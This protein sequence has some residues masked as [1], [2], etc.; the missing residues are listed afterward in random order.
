[1]NT[2]AIR[3]LPFSGKEKDWRMWSRKFLAS[4]VAKGYR[5]AV[6]P[7]DP[8]V[9]ADVDENKNA[10]SDLILS[11]QDE[12]TFGIID[13][14]KS[15][16][17]SDGDARMAWNELKKKYEPKTG[18]SEVRTKR[19]FNSSNLD[20]GQDPDEW[21]HNLILLQ[22]RLQTMGTTITERDVMI[23]ILGNLTEDYE[24]VIDYSE[25]ELLNGSLTLDALRETLRTKFEKLNKKNGGDEAALFAKQFKGMCKVCGKIGHKDDDCFN[26][27]KNKNKKAEYFKRF[28]KK[29]KGKDLSKIKCFNCNKMGHYSNK[30]PDKRKPEADD[31]EV[32]LMA[33]ETSSLK[34]A[35]KDLWIADT[36]ASC[37]MCNDLEGLEDVKESKRTIV[38]GNGDEMKSTMIGTW[39]G[40]LK[41]KEG[42]ETMITL[43]EVSYVPTLSANLL[44][45]T[46]VMIGGWELKGTNK[47]L[48]IQKGS[49]KIDFDKELKSGNG[50]LLGFHL[51]RNYQKEKA[52]AAQVKIGLK[53]AH[54]AFGH[55]DVQQVKA[56]L[57]NMGTET[58]ND[59]VQCVPCALAKAQQKAIS[60]VDETKSDKPG[61]RLCVDISS[62]KTKSTIKKRFWVL[63]IDQAT[64]MKWSYFVPKKD[65]QVEHL[66][67]LVKQINNLKDRKVEYVRCDNAGENKAFEKECLKQG[68]NITFEYT[69][70]NTPQQNGQV[71]RAFATLYGKMRAMLKSAEFSETE[72]ERFWHE[73]ASTATKTDNVLIRKGQTGS[74]FK[75]FYGKDPDYL[76][77]LKPFG[78]KGV[79]T[80]KRGG[81]IK[82]KL[83]DRGILCTFMG[84]ALNHTGDTFRMRNNTTGM[85]VI[86]RDVQWIKESE[87]KATEKKEQV[88][89]IPLFGEELGFRRNPEE[90][91]EFQEENVRR[92]LFHNYEEIPRGENTSGSETSGDEGT[93][94][95]DDRPAPP[96]PREVR[97]L[98]TYNNPGRLERGTNEEF[99]FCFLTKGGKIEI[100]E[101][102]TFQEAWN[103]PDEKERELWRASIRL[104]FRQMLR[105][106]VWKRKG[107][108]NN[109]P[110]GRKGLGMKW[111]FKKK[112]NGVYRS[113]L[114]AKGY[115]QLAGIDFQYNFAP[116][117]NDTTVKILL[118]LWLKKGYKTLLVDVKTAFLYG[119]LEEELYAKIPEGYE[120]F[121]K[122]E[123]GETIDYEYL[124][125]EKTIYGL[126]QAARAWWKEFIRVLTKE[127][128]FRQF[129]NDNCLLRKVDENGFIA[130]GVYVDDNF[131]IGDD[132]AIEAFLID[133]KDHFEIT[134]TEVE[135]F[136][137]CT[138][139]KG[140]GHLELHQPDLIKKMMREFGREI[141]GMKKYETPAPNGFKVIKTEDDETKLGSDEQTRY[142]MGVGS[143]LYLVKHSRPDLSN[144]TR[145][146]SKAMDGANKAQYKMMLRA[147]KYV[148]DTEDL[149]LRIQPD[150]RTEKKWSIKAYSDSDFAGDVDGRKSV[151]GYVIYMDG[152]PISWRSKGQKSVSLSST[153][154]E[155]MAVSEVT[156]ELLFIH[157]VMKFLGMEQKLP[158]IV[159]VDNVGAIY[160][161]QS[162]TT[163]NRTKHID[164]RYHFVR[165]FIED[166]IVKIIFVRS[167][168][169]DADIFTKNLGGELYGTHRT[170]VMK[171]KNEKREINK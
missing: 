126:V 60:K 67:G 91:V 87:V 166:G 156:M 72:K 75:R 159:N 120:R 152:M 76:P 121:L 132:K 29:G 64:S 45:L 16:Q 117:V 33:R 7:T 167:E 63:V 42:T 31:A 162:A 141:D 149:R 17:H 48:S 80:V 69:S 143:L 78:K 100:D 54:E 139:E 86:T 25:R 116:V 94:G 114:V 84:Y 109:L 19:E 79:M 49:L 34:E 106:G 128:N 50:F 140:D 104:E 24:N 81:E 53:E 97:N 92:R 163:S 107:G 142:R 110:S 125:L 70:R 51:E 82:A 39:K 165:E 133:I 171:G 8:T 119:R 68:L 47:T 112:K 136:I 27:E 40:L 71:E 134:T 138:I 123:F 93:N 153:E 58:T 88:E 46:T 26:L 85:I 102:M 62:V 1:M 98:R 127:M 9:D 13:E 2:T 66:I 32:A 22:R 73:C 164:V 14:S 145:E 129:E 154:A 124:L 130:I 41:N 101:P 115:D 74:P 38:I 150:E 111:V 151:S 137:G 99:Y 158:M 57:K 144:S 56:T 18:F 52:M 161:A 15:N 12:T 170:S 118:G 83:T 4:S 6:D 20:Q 89:D 135:D 95:R 11:M 23:Q 5:E 131:V 77:H 157:G 105:N 122:E 28:E 108:T 113:R 55:A 160:L 37:H 103:H 59:L 168:E 155:Y 35:K 10:Y 36:G 65:E 30:C 44:S 169:N 43:K 90:V 147:I 3:V 96:T 146:L 61:Q 148:K 21:V